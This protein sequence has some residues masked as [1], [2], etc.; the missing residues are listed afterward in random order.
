MSSQLSPHHGDIVLRVLRSIS[1]TNYSRSVFSLYRPL[2]LTVKSHAFRFNSHILEKLSLKFQ[3][4]SSFLAVTTSVAKHFNW[5]VSTLVY[6]VLVPLCSLASLVDKVNRD[7]VVA[8]ATPLIKSLNSQIAAPSFILNKFHAR[9]NLA[10][11]SI[12]N[13]HSFSWKARSFI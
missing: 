2:H 12:A 9:L 6:N 13:T 7:L 3:I 10:T 4:F 5:W 8:S 11:Q 1:L